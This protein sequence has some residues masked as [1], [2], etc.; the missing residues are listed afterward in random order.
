M[1]F[2]PNY[3]ITNRI[4]NCLIRI[5]AARQAMIYLPINPAVLASLRESARFD[6]THYSTMIEGNLLTQL[7][8]SQVIAKNEHFPGR[9]RDEK[10][11]LGYYKALEYV[12]RLAAEQRSLSETQIKTI[13][14][15]V[16]SGG[17]KRKPVPTPY[18]DGQNVIRD[19][20]SRAIVYMPPEASDVA[21]LMIGLNLNHQAPNQSG[22]T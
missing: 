9:E 1:P 13:H 22:G 21:T 4:A 20:R 15:L 8:V 6:S 16:M 3:R 12:E 5:E 10:E 18:R 19:S 17:T 2:T 11:V 14:A 7:E